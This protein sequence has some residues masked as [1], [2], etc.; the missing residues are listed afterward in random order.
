MSACTIYLYRHHRP[1]DG[2]AD[3]QVVVDSKYKFLSKYA[4]W[5]HA[6]PAQGE[7]VM[8]CSR[9]QPVEAGC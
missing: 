3:Y 4:H 9:S 7:L 6:Q 8:L 1:S 2:S 5:G